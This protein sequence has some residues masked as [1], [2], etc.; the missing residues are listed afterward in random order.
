MTVPLTI[1]HRESIVSIESM[2]LDHSIA[3][4]RIVVHSNLQCRLAAVGAPFLVEQVRDGLGAECAALVCTA[5]C[6]VECWSSKEIEQSEQSRRRATQMSAMESDLSEEVPCCRARR[7][8]TIAPAVLT[9]LTFGLCEDLDMSLVLDLLTR[10]VG[11]SVARDLGRAVD[12]AH[13]AL[14]DND[15]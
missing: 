3:H 5:K 13:E 11:A 10:V 2:G 1:A 8:E 15:G 7:E 4:A 14:R 6:D 9:R 12:D